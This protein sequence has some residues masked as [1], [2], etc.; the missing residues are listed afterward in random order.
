MV[1]L[2]V[3]RL[4][5][6]VGLGCCGVGGCLLFVVWWVVVGTADEKREERGGERRRRVKKRVRVPLS[7]RPVF[8]TEGHHVLFQDDA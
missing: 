8:Q 5:V 4:V 3:G 1:L 6:V 7:P 2:L